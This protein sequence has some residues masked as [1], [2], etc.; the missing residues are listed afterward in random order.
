MLNLVFELGV[1]LGT[2]AFFGLTILGSIPFIPI[3]WLEN[4]Y[5]D[6]DPP[7]ITLALILLV[8][9]NIAEITIE[10]ISDLIAQILMGMFLSLATIGW[11]ILQLFIP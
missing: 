5:I 2:L 11:F 3:L 10:G 9:A 1:I 8:Y 4:K 7:I 6:H